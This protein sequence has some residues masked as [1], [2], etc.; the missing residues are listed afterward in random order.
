LGI[1]TTISC[2]SSHANFVEETFVE[3][4]GALPG[5]S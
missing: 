2:S 5:Q 3:A 1:E 4:M